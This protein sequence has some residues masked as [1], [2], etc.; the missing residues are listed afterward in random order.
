MLNK[1][2]EYRYVTTTIERGKKYQ[3]FYLEVCRGGGLLG[4]L[5]VGGGRSLLGR[6]HHRRAHSTTLQGTVSLITQFHYVE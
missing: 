4:G 6:G 2:S 5:L 3:I 1:Y